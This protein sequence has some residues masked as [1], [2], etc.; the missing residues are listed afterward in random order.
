MSRRCTD[1]FQNPLGRIG[2]CGTA[3]SGLALEVTSD[4]ARAWP[5][6]AK[7]DGLASGC[8]QKDSVKALEEDCGGLVDRA[9]NGLAIIGELAEEAADRP[10]GL[11]VET[12]SGLVEEE[13]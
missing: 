13:E 4:G 8:E 11:A 2:F 9:Q 1:L 7:V 10:G 3:N 6:V 5:N 12:R